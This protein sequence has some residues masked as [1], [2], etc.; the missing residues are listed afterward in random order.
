[1]NKT[2]GTRLE[3][4]G[5]RYQVTFFYWPLHMDVFMLADQQLFADTGCSLEHLLIAINNRDRWRENQ[6]NLFYSQ[7]L[8]GP[9]F[10]ILNHLRLCLVTEA[11]PSLGKFK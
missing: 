9:C 1:M 7:D 8:M 4:Q 2:Y 5:W 10:Y 6:E 3:K 11:Y